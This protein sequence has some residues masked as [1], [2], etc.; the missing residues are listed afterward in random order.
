MGTIGKKR[1]CKTKGCS[2]EVPPQ[3]HYCWKCQKKKWYEKYPLK[4]VFG[5][6]KQ[7][8]KRRGIEF[9]LSLEEFKDFC[10]ETN[11]LELRGQTKESLS[12]DRKDPR[13]GYH[14]KNIQVLTLS[15][16][17]SK[18]ATIPEEFQIKKDCPF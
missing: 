16:N 9:R 7:N 3:N 6:L 10:E 2:N 5:F 8:A 12:I 1:Q 17:S 14:R 13:E 15:E 18:G 4:Y 11:Y